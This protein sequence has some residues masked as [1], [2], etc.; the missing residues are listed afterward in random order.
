VAGRYPRCPN[1]D[2][3]ESITN[4]SRCESGHVFCGKCMVIVR[5]GRAGPLLDTCPKCGGRANEHLGLVM[6]SRE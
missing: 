4:L 3:A 6:E 5:M 1:C 2:Y